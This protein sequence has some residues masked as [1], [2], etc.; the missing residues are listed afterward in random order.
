VHYLGGSAYL[1]VND[2]LVPLTAVTDIRTP[3]VEGDL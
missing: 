1:M 3:E 2:Q